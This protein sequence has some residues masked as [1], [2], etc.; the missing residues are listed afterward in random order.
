MGIT[1][2]T[3]M[4]YGHINSITQQSNGTPI[5]LYF[6]IL[7][8]TPG[9]FKVVGI[10]ECQTFLDGHHTM[11]RY[12]TKTGKWSSKGSFTKK[13]NAYYYK[14]KAEAEVAFKLLVNQAKMKLKDDIENA[15]IALNVLQTL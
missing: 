2:H 5:D 1:I 9:V 12:K 6:F 13:N 4:S 7:K 8:T 11:F 10:E 15:T 14:T 3:G